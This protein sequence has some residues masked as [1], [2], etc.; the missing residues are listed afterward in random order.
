MNIEKVESSNI[1][2]SGNIINPSTQVYKDERRFYT[3]SSFWGGVLTGIVA[4]LIFEFVIKPIV[5]FLS[6]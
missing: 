3:K 1:T 2:E 5:L 4:S 6:E